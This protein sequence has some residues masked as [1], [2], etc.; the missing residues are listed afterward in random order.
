M[1]RGRVRGA[2]STEGGCVALKTLDFN[3]GPD[4]GRCRLKSATDMTAAI[5]RRTRCLPMSAQ[6]GSRHTSSNPTSDPMS[7]DVGKVGSRSEPWISTSD[8]MS[9]DVDN[10][11]NPSKS[12]PSTSDPMSAPTSADVGMSLNPRHPTLSHTHTHPHPHVHAHA[13]THTHTHTHAHHLSPTRVQP[14]S[15]RA[16]PRASRDAQKSARFARCRSYPPAPW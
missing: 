8:P 5:Q 15:A 3:V 16:G 14:R 9:A 1:T 2:K 7:A 4:I 10:V 6:V 11:G 12:Q 13:H